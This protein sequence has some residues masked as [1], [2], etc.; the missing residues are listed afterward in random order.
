MYYSYT[1]KKQRESLKGQNT[2]WENLMFEY[3]L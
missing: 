3:A 1:N 2:Y